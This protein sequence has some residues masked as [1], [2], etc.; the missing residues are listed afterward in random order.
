ME[1]FRTT[2]AEL[3]PTDIYELVEKWGRDVVYN[4]FKV[5]EEDIQYSISQLNDNDKERLETHQEELRTVMESLIM[6][7]DYD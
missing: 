7:S 3:D 6:D 2:F 4:K 1:S 5:E